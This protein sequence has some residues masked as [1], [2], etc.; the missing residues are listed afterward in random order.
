MRTGLF[1][2]L[3]MNAVAVVLSLGAMLSL[4]TITASAATEYTSG[5]VSD[6]AGYIDGG[7]NPSSIGLITGTGTKDNTTYDN[8][9][10][11][12]NINGTYY[13]WK[14]ADKASI[15]G[16]ISNVQANSPDKVADDVRDITGGL[17]ISADTTTAAN[18]LTG[19]T[20]V[21]STM[22][23]IIVVLITVGMA[24]F[25]AFD[26]C[27]IAFPVFRNKCEEAKQSGQ[28]IMASS[29][30]TANGE[31]KIRF[32]TD[33]AQYAVTAADT[34]QSGKNPFVI[35][36]GKRLISYIALSILVFILLTGNIDIFTRLAIKLVSGILNVIQGI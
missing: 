28:G 2:R 15:Q 26:L 8:S 25:S 34:V 36:F 22:L 23:G 20:G 35:Y 14:S 3:A 7:G 29:K 17:N 11:C 13:Y 5:N 1:K 16:K 30:K 10:D 21:I 31:T 9:Y 6:I 33:D 32:V 12:A 24:V 19:F 27:Y 18:T 4:N